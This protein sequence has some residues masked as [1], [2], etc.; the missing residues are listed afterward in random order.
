MIFLLLLVLLLLLLVFLRLFLFLLLL[1]DILN[2]LVVLLRTRSFLNSDV[3][4]LLVNQ[5]FL[6]LERS[7]LVGEKLHHSIRR[8]LWINLHKSRYEVRR[9]SLKPMMGTRVEIYGKVLSYCHTTR[10]ANRDF[11][12][13]RVVLIDEYKT[14][15]LHSSPTLVIM[16][17]SRV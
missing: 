6:L 5:R 12:T 13:A 2:H 7:E 4:S 10:F 14:S 3:G 16:Q 11:G 15:Q 17:S 9:S 1:L 8:K